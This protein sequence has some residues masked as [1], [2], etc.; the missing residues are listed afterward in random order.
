MYLLTKKDGKMDMATF[1]YLHSRAGLGDKQT[2]KSWCCA[3]ARLLYLS[4][5]NSVCKEM[6]NNFPYADL[7]DTLK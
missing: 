4:F 1:L 3:A 2:I 6:T 5:E 7:T